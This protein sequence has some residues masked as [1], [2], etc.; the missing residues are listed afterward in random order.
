[1]LSG[2]IRKETISISICA[3]LWCNRDVHG[4]AAAA[5]VAAAVVA[6]AVKFL[7]SFRLF[8]S[9]KLTMIEILGSFLL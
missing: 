1:M 6:A 9:K 4:G 5:V 7:E 2:S 3:D 8:L